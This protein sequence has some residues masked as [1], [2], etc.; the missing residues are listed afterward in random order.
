MPDSRTHDFLARRID[1]CYLVA[2]WTKVDEKRRAHLERARYYRS[3]L[4]SLATPEL[5]KAV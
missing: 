5:S 3:L 1:R 4:A 2:A